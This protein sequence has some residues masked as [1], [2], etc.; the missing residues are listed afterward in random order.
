MKEIKR[1]GFLVAEIRY[2]ELL[3]V[4]EKLNA[5]EKEQREAEELHQLKKS[6]K[7]PGGKDKGRR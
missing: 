4:L 1:E 3:P 6:L 2:N 7:K 5:L